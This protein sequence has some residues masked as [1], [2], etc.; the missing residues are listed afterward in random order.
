MVRPWARGFS[1]DQAHPNNFLVWVR[2]PG[3]PE[4]MYTK[5]LLKSIGGIIGP[6]AKIDQNTENRSRGQFARLAVFVNL[7]QPLVSKIV[8]DGRIQ[9]VEYE[10][11]PL[12]CFG[13][14]RYGHSKEICSY[15]HVLEKPS[16]MEGDFRP[17][18]VPKTSKNTKEERFD[19]WMLVE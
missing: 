13:C 2:L 9:H 7:D 8:I 18:E 10:S 6:V 3:L 11:L 5:S 4:G 12:V 17:Q 14:G 19:P 16:K 15:S 1:T